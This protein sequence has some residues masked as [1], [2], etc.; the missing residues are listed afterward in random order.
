MCQ[1]SLFVK[2][3]GMLQSIGDVVRARYDLWLQELYTD[4]RDF[5]P[6]IIRCSLLSK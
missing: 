1:I 3:Q 5:K 4:N 6:L 2:L